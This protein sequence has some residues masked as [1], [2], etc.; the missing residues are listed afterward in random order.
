[1]PTELFF[2]A[3]TL[4][5][6]LDSLIML[7]HPHLINALAFAA[8]RRKDAIDGTGKFLSRVLPKGDQA[9]ADCL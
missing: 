1:V 9:S 2:S 3:Y 6:Y 5:P 4:D 8:G 7:P